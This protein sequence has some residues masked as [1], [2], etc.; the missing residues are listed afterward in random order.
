MKLEKLGKSDLEVPIWCLGTMT[1]GNQT[2]EADGHAQIDAALDAGLTFMDTAEMYPV[3]PAK[4]ETVGGT[5]EII[6]NW[7]AK[8]GRRNDVLIAT[9]IVGPSQL[10]RDGRGIDAE[11]LREAVD[12][13]LRRLQTDVI[14]L[15]QLH[16]PQRGS[17]H[18]RQHWTFAPEEQDRAATQ[19]NMEEVMAE[20]ARIRDAGKV[21]HFGT[22]N[23]SAWG[24][25]RWNQLAAE[26]G[27]PRMET[28]QNE[29]SLL[30]R[31]YDTDM[32]EMSHQEEVSLLAYSPLAA[33]LLTG[34]Y[35]DGARP[36]GSR[37]S[38]NGDL[39]G[40]ITPRAEAATE[41][42][43]ALAAEHGVDPVHMA[44][45]W[46]AERPFMGSVIFG[47]TTMPQLQHILSG[48]EFK[49]TDELRDGIASTYRDHPLPY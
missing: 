36:E 8:S 9:K 38:I 15:F 19:A 23:E 2:P 6:G 49:L 22:S 44:L 33:G 11:T 47:A 45:A 13:S 28:V 4:A 1:F 35:A 7:V 39:G 21:R 40:R 3:N 48:M 31:M 20:M 18:F 29:Y 30:C 27:G 32:A 41:A 10:A 46:A 37:A 34:K 17:Y 5:E 12:C 14:D 24:M 43:I 16:W 25:T 26:T 42:Y